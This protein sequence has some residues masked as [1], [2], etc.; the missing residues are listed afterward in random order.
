MSIA[1]DIPIRSNGEEILASWFNSFR[2]TL[3]NLYGTE[4][5]S[6]GS[7]SGSSS[8]TGANVTSLV[9]DNTATRRAD[10]EYLIVTATKV[11]S[12]DFRLLYDGTNWTKFDGAVEGVDSGIT[13][14]VD[15]STGQV[16][17]DSGA[18]TFTLAY[19]VTTFNI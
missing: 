17:Y 10:I 8:Q 19:K 6:L 1:D 14:D 15:A 13:L 18:E 7:F 12:G 9:F 3:I 11:E 2:T 5:I 16:E 4:S